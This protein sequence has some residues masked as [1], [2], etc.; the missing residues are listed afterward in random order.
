M[1]G[2]PCMTKLLLALPLSGL[3]ACVGPDPA[4]DVSTAE[5]AE[6]A[7]CTLY[8]LLPY[9]ASGPAIEYGGDIYC[10]PG[11]KLDAFIELQAKA[12]DGSWIRYAYNTFDPL[13]V[14]NATWV[15]L[16]DEP[17]CSNTANAYTYRTKFHVYNYANGNTE[18]R[19]SDAVQITCK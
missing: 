9:K 11:K 19:Y 18:V 12:A 17:S 14:P 7:D 2:P 13:G 16:R 4:D 10:S 3:V 5:Q 1:A 8:A 6:L 15:H